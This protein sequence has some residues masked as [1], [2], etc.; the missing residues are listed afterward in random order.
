M[1][2][3]NSSTYA[4]IYDRKQLPC[5]GRNRV[6]LP[7]GPSQSTP[8]KL[9]LHGRQVHF[10]LRLETGPIHCTPVHRHLVSNLPDIEDL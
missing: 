10:S 5:N 9:G 6:K 4:I 3:N 2:N 7:R 1:E 8:G